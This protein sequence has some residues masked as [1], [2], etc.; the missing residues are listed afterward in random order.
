MK[1]TSPKSNTQQIL[2]KMNKQKKFISMMFIVLLIIQI[3]LFYGVT[4]LGEQLN[5]NEES[6]NQIK[7]ESMDTF[8]NRTIRTQERIML[9]SIRQQWIQ[10]LT[11]H[12]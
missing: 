3:F 1:T 11:I 4:N 2:A 8:V 9:D 5:K 6:L 12:S 7:Y 10:Y